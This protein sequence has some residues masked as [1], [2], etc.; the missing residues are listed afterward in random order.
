[1]NLEVVGFDQG[2]IY[3]MV[4]LLNPLKGIRG[5]YQE[6]FDRSENARELIE[7]LESTI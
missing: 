6:I 5:Q 7:L 4:P 3:R 1:M 2:D